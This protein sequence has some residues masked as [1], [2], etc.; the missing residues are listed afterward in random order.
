MPATHLEL[1]SNSIEFSTRGYYRGNV[2][3][4]T[5]LPE[6]NEKVVFSDCATI[7]YEVKLSNEEDFVVEDYSSKIQKIY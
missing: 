3:F 6:T 5:L 1:L 2:A 7:P 4:S